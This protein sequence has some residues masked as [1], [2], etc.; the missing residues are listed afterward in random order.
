MNLEEFKEIKPQLLRCFE[1]AILK[2][3]RKCP[4]GFFSWLGMGEKE[5]ERGCQEPKE[6]S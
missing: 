3:A 6:P 4:S 1:E 2:A 5:G